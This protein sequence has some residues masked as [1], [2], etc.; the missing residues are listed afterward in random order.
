MAILTDAELEDFFNRNGHG[1]I[2]VL[3]P[4]SMWAE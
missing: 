4:A 1:R 3:P 2:A